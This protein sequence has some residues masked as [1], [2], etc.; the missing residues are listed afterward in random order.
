VALFDAWKQET[1]QR[2]AS[3]ALFE[4]P[5]L[6]K[7]VF[8]DGYVMINAP[9]LKAYPHMRKIVQDVGCD[10]NWCTK[11]EHHALDYGSGKNRLSILFDSKARPK[12]QITVTRSN[13][14]VSVS[15]F[16]RFNEKPASLQNMDPYSWQYEDAVFSSP[17][18]QQW[19]HQQPVDVKIS[20]IKGFNNET[21][22][23]KEPYVG[24]V[25]QFVKDLDRQYDLEGRVDNLDGIG[26]TSI[27][28]F[29][30]PALRYTAPSV[31]AAVRREA[32]RLNDGSSFTAEDPSKI[33]SLIQQAYRNVTQSKE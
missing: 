19:A 23:Q 16:L 26:L 31:V 25:Q 13:P 27:T 32:R 28:P 9:D 18:F 1:R 5:S 12:A 4:D 30:F 8:D 3:R 21:Q 6:D 29:I 33:E 2:M 20:E 22:L 15:D 7:K 11:L 14:N 10:G 24:K 17:E